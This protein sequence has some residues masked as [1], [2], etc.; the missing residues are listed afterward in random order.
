RASEAKAVARVL[1][2]QYSNTTVVDTIVCIDGTEVIGAYLAEELTNAGIMS[3]NTHQTIYITTPETN[4]SGQIMFRE[5]CKMM[6]DQKNVLILMASATTGSTLN[7]VLESVLY[8][9]GR[10]SGVAA[11]FSNISKI[12]GMDIYSIFNGQDVPG[13]QSHLPGKCPLCAAGT[14]IDALVNG[15]GYSKL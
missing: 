11:I 14:K 8:Y 1:A 9:G 10:V 12:A 6:I 3:M 2:Q 15:Y 4:A 13:Y 5:N 7:S